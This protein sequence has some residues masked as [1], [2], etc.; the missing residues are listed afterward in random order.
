MKPQVQDKAWDDFILRDAAMHV[1]HDPLLG[2][3]DDVAD[4]FNHLPLAPAEYWLS[5]L[6]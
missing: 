6:V 5:C 1:F 4:F 2:W 3:T